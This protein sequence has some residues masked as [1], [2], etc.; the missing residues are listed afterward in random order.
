MEKNRYGE[1]ILSLFVLLFL[2]VSPFSYAETVLITNSG[3]SVSSLAADEVKDLF[4]G[5]K[6]DLGGQKVILVVQKVSDGTDAFLKQYLNKTSAQFLNFWKQQVFSGNGKLP[7]MFETEDE[8]VSFVSSNPGSLAC[9]S[10][11]TCE[12]N[13][14]KVQK[15]SIN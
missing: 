2:M 1:L 11:A 7:K 4:G 15:I 8:I 9:I 10:S 12:A 6:T 3:S 5:K 13:K 14:D